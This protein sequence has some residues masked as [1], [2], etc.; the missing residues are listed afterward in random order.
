M[1]LSGLIDL[2]VLNNF[3][4]ESAGFQKFKF[5]ALVSVANLRSSDHLSWWILST[6]GTLSKIDWDFTLEIKRFC[7]VSVV[8]KY[9][10]Q[11][12]MLRISIG[13]GIVS[14]LVIICMVLMFQTSLS[15]T[16]IFPSSQD[17][18]GAWYADSVGSPKT[19]CVVLW[20]SIVKS[21]P[22]GPLNMI[23]PLS[24]NTLVFWFTCPKIHLLLS[25]WM[26]LKYFLS[27]S[28]CILVPEE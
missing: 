11:G 28:F 6:A 24:L 9:L 16:A 12:D 17:Y 7:W 1:H 18:F 25:S 21:V 14:N 26:S 15:T 8:T 2:W 27:W 22:P 20:E 5:P 19:F 4:V 23:S 10:W 13:F 3:C